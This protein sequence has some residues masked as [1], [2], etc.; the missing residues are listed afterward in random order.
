[1]DTRNYPQFYHSLGL[2]PIPHRNKIP[3]VGSGWQKYSTQ[4]PDTA[5]L[6]IWFRNTSSVGLVM[7]Q[8]TD[9][10]GRTQQL[11]LLDFDFKNFAP[12]DRQTFFNALKGELPETI[13]EKIRCAP[14]ERTPSGGLHIY[15]YVDFDLNSPIKN[16]KLVTLKNGDK[17]DCILEIKAN[18][19]FA[20]CY[21]SEGYLVVKEEYWFGTSEV[22]SLNSS[23]WADFMNACEKLDESDKK[24][25]KPNLTRL[26]DYIS[27]GSVSLWDDY[28]FKVGCSEVLEQYGFTFWSSQGDVEYWTRP[29]KEEGGNSVTVF[30]A[31]EGKPTIAYCHTSS[32]PNLDSSE[33]YTSSALFC[34][35]MCNNNWTIAAK[36]LKEMGYKEKRALDKNNKFDFKKCVIPAFYEN[37]KYENDKVYYRSNTES[38]KWVLL[39]DNPIYIKHF[40]Y[41]PREDEISVCLTWKDDRNRWVEKTF[42]KIDLLSDGVKTI[43]SYPGQNFTKKQCPLVSDYLSILLREHSSEIETF[44]RVN[45][46]GWHNENRTFLLN[47]ECIGEHVFSKLSHRHTIC[48]SRGTLEDWLNTAIDLKD[49][50]KFTFGMLA[51][52]ATPFLSFVKSPVKQNPIIEIVGLAGQGKTTLLRYAAS[53]WGSTEVESGDDTKYIANFNSTQYGLMTLAS[54]YNHIPFI[55]D[56]ATHTMISSKKNSRTAVKFDEFVQSF[57]AGQSKIQGSATEGIREII[58]FNSLMMYST[59]NSA[60]ETQIKTFGSNSRYISIPFNNSDKTTSTNRFAQNIGDNYGLFGPHVLRTLLVKGKLEKFIHEVNLFADKISHLYD[61]KHHT[62]YRNLQQILKIHAISEVINEWFF[63]GEFDIEAIFQNIKNLAMQSKQESSPTEVAW[64][65]LIEYIQTNINRF[66]SDVDSTTFTSVNKNSGEVFGRITSDKIYLSLGI[67]NRW[68]EDNGYVSKQIG[69]EFRESNKVVSYHGSQ[70]NWY[71]V[72]QIKGLNTKV[73]IIDREAL[74]KSETD[75]EIEDKIIDQ[76]LEDTLDE[77]TDELNLSDW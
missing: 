39:L 3:S 74:G 56:E 28:N 11:V 29:G 63:D 9:S 17:Y 73:L 67:F 48:E 8:R 26:N 24:R 37:Y 35:L 10:V 68:C 5:D 27:D 13:K 44:E 76:I 59:E 65:R 7:N 60:A 49:S 57:A 23:E 71:H 21:P 30:P 62:A 20:A 64:E 52:V 69:K 36:K 46:L 70:Y 4:Q 50:Y 12:Q 58:R 31:T 16:Q 54:G 47:N 34:R 61:N 18:A 33:S 75:K 66:E 38:D 72:R 32:V 19:G 42:R 77:K 55:A 40:V 43:G 53:V 51:S 41:D 14:T 25:Q 22:P 2:S 45:N 15:V 1:M 6:A